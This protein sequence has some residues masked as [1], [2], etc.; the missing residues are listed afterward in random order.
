MQ[1]SYRV[2]ETNY[3]EARKLRLRSI[4]RFSLVKTIFFWVFVL[5]CLMLL[6]TIVQKS[7]NHRR[8]VEDAD[9]PPPPP[10]QTSTAVWFNAAP[11][12][13]I[14]VVFAGVFILVIPNQVRR[15]Y[16]ND[17]SM[18]GEFSVDIT[19]SSV[20]TRNTA[21]TSS[22]TGWNVYDFWSEGRG[23]IILVF[24]SGTYFILSLAG[25]S[26]IQRD[27]LRSTLTAILPKK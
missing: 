17:P 25:L 15:M 6:W 14:A 22:E 10:A 8:Q 18:Q 20:S 26:D 7:A 4:R 3:F 9:T 12:G 23:V 16:R 1:F 21:G 24:K 19:Q 13:I 5:V 27:E 11:L 2:S